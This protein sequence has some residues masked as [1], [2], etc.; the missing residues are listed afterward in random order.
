MLSTTFGLQSWRRALPSLSCHTGEVPAQSSSAAKH[1]FS[2]A[3]ILFAR[4]E[5]VILRGHRH[6]LLQLQPY[7]VLGPLAEEMDET[8]LDTRDRNFALSC[9][10]ISLLR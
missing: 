2:A 7:V 4:M 1:T 8:S 5:L 3:W 10:Q 6:S 9:E